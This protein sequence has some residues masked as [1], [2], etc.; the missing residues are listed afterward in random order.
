MQ[1][2]EIFF[3]N[4]GSA[5]FQ[6]AEFVHCYDDMDQMAA[7]FVEYQKTGNTS[8]WE[9]NEPEFRVAYSSETERNGGYLCVT[10]GCWADLDDE[11]G[12]YNVSRF[13]AALEATG[14]I[15]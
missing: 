11:R 13:V 7:D 15:A 2:F 14:Y 3:H 5:T 9:G 4:N 12:G 1:A 10:D 8:E 6:T